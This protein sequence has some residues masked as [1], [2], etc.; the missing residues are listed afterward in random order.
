MGKRAVIEEI[1][2]MVP[3]K[4]QVG[5]SIYELSESPPDTYKKIGPRSSRRPMSSQEAKRIVVA[6]RERVRLVD[7]TD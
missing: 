3:C 7:E 1:M 5:K 6:A 2:S 4:W